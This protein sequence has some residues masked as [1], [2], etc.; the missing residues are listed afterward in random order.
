MKKTI[1]TVGILFLIFNSFTNIYG[2]INRTTET[3]VADILA[4]L[5]TND[6][7]HSNKLMQEIIEVENRI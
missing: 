6:L 4:Q 3:A 2:Q 1:I 7:E 5:P